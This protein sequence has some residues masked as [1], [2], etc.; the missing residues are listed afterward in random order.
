ME[1]LGRVQIRSSDNGQYWVAKLEH[2]YSA[3][4]LGSP[5]DTYSWFDVM[6]LPGA[7]HVAFRSSHQAGGRWTYVSARPDWYGKL[8]LQAPDSADW[9]TAVGGNETYGLV[10]LGGGEVAF[11]LIDPSGFVSAHL[12]IVDSRAGDGHPLS[13]RVRIELFTSVGQRSGAYVNVIGKWERFRFVGA[14][15]DDLE[16]IMG[17]AVAE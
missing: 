17:V 8:Q 2:D 1:S 7:N 6:K 10:N 15:G 16:R 13:I 3:I 11:R 5:H 4:V 9:I 12:D 14:A